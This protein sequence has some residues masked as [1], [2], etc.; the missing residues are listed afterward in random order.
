M[1]DH[2]SYSGLESDTKG[3]N[4]DTCAAPAI[5]ALPLAAGFPATTDSFCSGRKQA[6]AVVGRYCVIEI[7]NKPYTR[8]QTGML[9]AGLKK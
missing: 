2:G 8:L 9:K 7:A 6:C 4:L 3:G 5:A 1:H